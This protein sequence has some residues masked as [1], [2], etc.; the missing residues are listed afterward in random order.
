MTLHSD[1]RERRSITSRSIAGGQP[2]LRCTA[3]ASS[4]PRSTRPRSF[5]RARAPST[6]WSTRS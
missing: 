4:G 3:N 2:A 6:L 5:R 1:G